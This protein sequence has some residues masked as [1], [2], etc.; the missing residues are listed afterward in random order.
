ME[1]TAMSR[2][3]IQDIDVSLRAAFDDVAK[4]SVPG[5]FME[6]LEKL[7]AAEDKAAITEKPSEDNV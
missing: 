7:R 1:E 4:Q 3:T 6:L 5:E 2:R